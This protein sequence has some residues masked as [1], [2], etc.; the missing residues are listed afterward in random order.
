MTGPTIEGIDVRESF[1]FHLYDLT[2]VRRRSVPEDNFPDLPGRGTGLV[3]ACTD[4]SSSSR[5]P[6]FLFYNL[7][8]FSLYS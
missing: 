7:I 1:I 3:E 8:F 4:T 6:E 5:I 2:T